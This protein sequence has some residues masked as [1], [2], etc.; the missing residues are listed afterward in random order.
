MLL[1]CTRHF[2]A[3]PVLADS[4]QAFSSSSLAESQSDLLR[5]SG[6][7]R[8]IFVSDLRQLEVE[9]TAACK[10]GASSADGAALPSELR[11]LI[12]SCFTATSRRLLQ[13]SPPASTLHT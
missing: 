7:L 3:A 10:A 12:G 6:R 4:L 11:L 9:S 8:I 2:K 5:S 13:V 1:L